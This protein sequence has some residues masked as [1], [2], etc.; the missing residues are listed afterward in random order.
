[1]ADMSELEEKLFKEKSDLGEAFENL[2]NDK[3]DRETK[4]SSI[5]LNARL[6]KDQISAILIFDELKRIGLLP[7]RLELARQL[8]RLSISEDGKGR[9]EKVRIA[10]G[11]FEQQNGGGFLGG[12][13][14]MFT[15][16]QD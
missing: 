1:M 10:V 2:D 4:M 16:R 13:K 11:Q 5:D 12:L 14:R 7:Q 6:T 8:K 9:E 3:L 15:P